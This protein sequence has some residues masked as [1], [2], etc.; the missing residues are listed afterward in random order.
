MKSRHGIFYLRLNAHGKEWRKSLHTRDPSIARVA[1]YKLGA[2]IAGMKSKQN[3]G[4]G[5]RLHADG[6]IDINTDGSAEDHGRVLEILPEVK[7][8]SEARLA[9]L[10]AEGENELKQIYAELA[11]WRSQQSQ[12]VAITETIKPS[13]TIEVAIKKYQGARENDTKMGT[14]RTWSSCY[15]KLIKTFKGR[16]IRSISP[17]EIT[18][19]IVNPIGGKSPETISK[20]VDAWHRMFQWQIDHKLMEYNPVIKPQFRNVAT[21]RLKHKYKNERFPF[22]KNDINALFSKEH[23]DSLKRPEDAWI[24]LIGLT[25]GARL[26]SI[27]RLK[28]KDFTLETIELVAE[29][30]KE[31]IHRLIPMHSILIKANFHGYINEIER[32]FG[33]ESYVF[34]NMNEV[35]G[36][37]SHAY[38]M[39]FRRQRIAL[40][41]QEGKVFHSLRSTLITALDDANVNGQARRIYVGQLIGT[42]KLQNKGTQERNLLLVLC[43][44]EVKA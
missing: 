37:R 3:L 13:I 23:L 15:N 11:V 20:D 7:K 44:L 43:T 24:Q 5:M 8:L 31:F 30:D 34:P 19:I 29:F 41:L 36:R 33:K 9:E 21:K 32:K 2:T 17:E 18:H 6:S 14:K 42:R 27:A 40:G 39:R 38:S 1:A 4:Y 26:E 28:V 16:E 12:Q 35:E 22:D 25:T 10:K